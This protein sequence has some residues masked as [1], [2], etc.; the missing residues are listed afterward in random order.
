MFGNKVKNVQNKLEVQLPELDSHSNKSV[1]SLLSDAD[2]SPMPSPDYDAPS[3]EPND[4]E[5]ELR[6]PDEEAIPMPSTPEQPKTEE[7]PTTSDMSISEYLT[8]LA[9]GEAG[10]NGGHF[11]YQDPPAATAWP[12]PKVRIFNNSRT[13][14][15][16]VQ[17]SRHPSGRFTDPSGKFRLRGGI[18]FGVA[19]KL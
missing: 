11:F 7:A 4:Q 3:P 2:L 6:L 18:Q 1:A 12:A 13:C 9:Q 14:T 17:S 16:R 19:L 8:K 5:T 10:Q 15:L